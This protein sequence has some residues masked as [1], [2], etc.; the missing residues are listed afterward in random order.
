[1]KNRLTIWLSLLCL[2]YPLTGETAI[3]KCTEDNSVVYRDT[4]CETGRASMLLATVAPTRPVE[5]YTGRPPEFRPEPLPPSQLQS[6]AIALG[7]TDT[8]VLNMRG[9][10]RPSKIT[11][12]KD[13]KAWHEEWSYVS[14]QDEQVQRQL[15]FTNGRLAAI[16]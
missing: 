16:L 3:Y 14:R 7:M 10:G 15:Q 2:A 8:Q 5:P 1:M 4:P 9:W 12:N 11:R 13:A 6:T